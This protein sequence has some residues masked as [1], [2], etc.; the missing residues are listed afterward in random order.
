MDKHYYYQNSVQC[1]EAEIDFVEATYKKIKGRN[2]ITLREDFCGTAQTA[3]EWVKRSNDKVAWGVD[4]D[5]LVM[6]WG[7]DNNIAALTD[8]QQARIQ[9][10][11]ADVMEAP[12]K[13][14]DVVLAMNF[15]YFIFMQRELMLQYFRSVHKSLNDDGLFFLDAFGGYE[16]AKELTEERECDGFTYI[17]EQAT[18]NPITSEMQCYIHFET[19]EG[20]RMDKAFDY[21]WRIWTLPEITEMLKTAGFKSADVYWEGTDEKTGEG[22]GV[23]SKS[24]Q[25]TADAGWVCYLVAEK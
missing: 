11:E 2:A 6:Q 22:D 24:T 13:D 1:V 14:V 17:W 15:S 3:C 10:S 12:V 7:E 25:G 9:L 19:D 23:Y 21:Y 8:S 4:L 18:F 16:A 5:P 20:V